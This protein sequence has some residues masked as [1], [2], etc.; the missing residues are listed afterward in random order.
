MRFRPPPGAFG[1]G[2]LTRR[3]TSRLTCRLTSRL[4]SRL[5]CRGASLDFVDADGRRLGLARFSAPPGLRGRRLKQREN[6]EKNNEDSQNHPE[7][8]PS[9]RESDG[10]R[11]GADRGGFGAIKHA[12]IFQQPLRLGAI[13]GRQAVTARNTARNNG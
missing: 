4:T 9:K 13:Q 8:P 6:P 2:I 7:N 10:S 3:L 5:T 12:A 1:A 11:F